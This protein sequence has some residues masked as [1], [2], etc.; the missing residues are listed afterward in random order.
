MRGGRT[1]VS[2]SNDGRQNVN[3]ASNPASGD[4]KQ[5]LHTE[6][7]VKP[8]A[9][10]LA[11]LTVKDYQALY[12]EAARDLEGFWNDIAQEFV[13]ETPWTSVVEGQTPDARWFVGGTAQY[14]DELSRSARTGE[15]LQQDSAAVGGGRWRRAQV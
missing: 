14:Y 9:D 15:P 12:D 8:D 10:F 5:L 6:V 2:Q 7:R 3:I 11:S 1:M 4:F 13:W